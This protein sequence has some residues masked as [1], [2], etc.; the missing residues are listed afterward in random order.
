[1]SCYTRHLREP[2]LAAGLPFDPP[3]KREADRRI[4]DGLGLGHADCPEVWR[5]VKALPAADLATLL[6]A[7][8]PDQRPTAEFT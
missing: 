7:A 5:Q 4:R 3:G 8:G 2:I 6:G 1:M